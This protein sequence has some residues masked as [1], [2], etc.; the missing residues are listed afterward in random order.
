MG[1]DETEKIR[2]QDQFLFKCDF[3]GYST[4]GSDSLEPIIIPGA[5]YVCS[6]FVLKQLALNTSD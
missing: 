5:I 3:V 1:R 6:S 4:Q 2:C